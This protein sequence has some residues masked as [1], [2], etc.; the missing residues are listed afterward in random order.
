MIKMKNFEIVYGIH[1]VEEALLSNKKINKLLIKKSKKLNPRI[2]KLIYQAEVKN[3]KIKY[4]DSDEIKKYVPEANHQGILAFIQKREGLSTCS[5]HEDIDLSG[6]LYIILD[7]ITDI[8]NMGAIL[9]SAEYFKV[10]GV[11]LPKNRSACINETV[12]KISAGAVFYLNIIYV[13]NIGY[14]I[15]KLKKNNF[16]IIGADVQG[17][18]NI[19]EFEFPKKSVIIIGNE[20]KGISRLIKT[21]LD[22]RIKIPQFGHT[23][24]LNVSVA[25][26]IFLFQYRKF[27]VIGKS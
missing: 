12:R 11:I 20:E 8:H 7:H 2:V 26:A 22:Y 4:V 19:F 15:E 10:D 24:S 14:E 5:L 1:P 17:N 25:S 13:S 21:K 23:E 3:I 16:W 27:Y 9:R 18:E 6:N